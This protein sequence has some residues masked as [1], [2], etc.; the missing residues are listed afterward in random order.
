MIFIHIHVYHV[1]THPNLTI[2]LSAIIYAEE[3]EVP[4]IFFTKQMFEKVFLCLKVITHSEFK[5]YLSIKSLHSKVFAV[6]LRL[7]DP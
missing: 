2:I 5:D 6:K 1:M 3:R 7:P 4:F